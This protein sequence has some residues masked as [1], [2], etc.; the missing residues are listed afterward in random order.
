MDLVWDPAKKEPF[1]SG[2]REMPKW[3]SDAAPMRGERAGFSVVKVDEFRFLIVGGLNEQD[4]NLHNPTTVHMFDSRTN[5]W[6]SLPDISIG[7]IRCGACFCNGKVYVFGGSH[8]DETGARQCLGTIDYMDL[9]ASS[10]VWKSLDQNIPPRGYDGAVAVKDRFVYLVSG[11]R[12]EVFIFDT[13]MGTVH[14][15]PQLTCERAGCG[16]VLVDH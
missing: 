12:R 9:A 5:I 2:F 10:L 3:N 11:A 6:S 7:P 16:V 8:S 13:E 15:G 4:E 1:L 14:T